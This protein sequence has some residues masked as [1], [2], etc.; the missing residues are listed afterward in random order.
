[1]QPI[2]PAVGGGRI[3]LL[4]LYHG[5]GAGN[6]TTYVGTYDWPGEPPRDNQISPTLREITVPL[7]PEHFAAHEALRAQVGGKVVIDSAFPQQ[8]HLSP[9]YLARA[10][11]AAREA[12][13][14]I[15]SHPWVHPLV[16][17]S[18]DRRRQLVV[19]DAHNVEGMLRMSLLDDGGQ[20]AQ[21]VR[22]VIRVEK[23]LC[24]EADVVVA[25]SKE[26]LLLFHELYGVPLRKLRLS[27]NGVFTERVR[28]ASPQ[29]RAQHK[30]RLEI[31]HPNAAIFIGSGYR[32]NI[33]AAE[34]IIRDIA[35]RLP[36]V[37]FVIAGGVG[38]CLSD[39]LFQQGPATNVRITGLLSDEEKAS[40]LAACDI[41]LNPMFGGSG[42]NIKMFDY[43]A[44]G[45][46]VVTTEIGARGIDEI[47]ETAFLAE[48]AGQFMDSINLLLH[49]PTVWRQMSRAARRLARDLYSWERI[50]RNLGILL[51]RERAHLG[52]KRPFFSIIV[53]TY[54][55]HGHLAVLA[56]AL[57]R[58]EEKNFEV[59][60]VDQSAQPW[61]GAGLES[62]LDLLY[63]HTEVRGAVIARN[64]GAFLARGDVLAFTDDDCTPDPGWLL[65]SRPYFDRPEVVGV[66]GYIRS[67]GLGDPNYRSVTNEG[68]AGLG[69]KTANLLVRADAFQLVG[70]FDTRFDQPHFR[71]DTDL[72][73]R[74]QELGDIPFSREASVYH[75]PHARSAHRE[76]VAARV[77]FFEKDGLLLRKHPEKYRQLFASEEQWLY[78]RDFSRY[79][80]SGLVKYR[81]PVPDYLAPLIAMETADATSP[82]TGRLPLRERL[83][84]RSRTRVTN[85][86]QWVA[87]ADRE[88]VQAAARSILGPT[89]DP[90]GL[91]R[92]SALLESGER[93][94]SEIVS[95]LL[96][97]ANASGR[98]CGFVP[99]MPEILRDEAKYVFFL[100]DLMRLDGEEFVANLYRQLLRRDPDPG[101]L[102]GN[103][104]ALSRGALKQD[105]VLNILHSEEAA[106]VGVSVIGLDAELP[107][108]ASPGSLIRP[109]T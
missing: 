83:G 102:S 67:A 99:V 38:G 18:L 40:Y 16:K 28:P 34:Y 12:D 35:P 49:H 106:R 91:N 68:L 100:D 15:F 51:G 92:L 47:G 105:I 44:A 107:S 93:S 37:L 36:S 108:G 95:E 10:R 90:E 81:V 3:R 63:I 70:G 5:L 25:C 66:E 86:S 54:E 65:N 31:F 23:E 71:E 61:G 96:A 24:H 58:Q 80:F 76:S 98:P 41:G 103:M 8:A 52:N 75:P 42:T 14:V 57:K 13:V 88:F 17:D 48:P 30:R 104:Y 85:V 89:S 20:G 39:F 82:A 4:G 109:D 46:P 73:W 62:G 79:F 6:Q 55:R 1:M 87:Y 19:Y 59:V 32:F 27:P 78:F 50:S 45:I 97:Q 11:E 7:S 77:R 101:G 74:L 94:R 69:F 29:E 9:A 2:T 53:P 72:G 26:E 60:V 84:A 22:D 21:I 56:D 43:L 64:L 33:E